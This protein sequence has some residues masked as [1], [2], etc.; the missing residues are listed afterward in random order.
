M[1]RKA[2]QKPRNAA[3]AAAVKKD[4][5]ATA[6]DDARLVVNLPER[7]H[8]AIKLRAVERG[9]SIRDY[10]L[11]LLAADKLPME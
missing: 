9:I 5:K 4:R 7:V 6:A 2:A 8:R 10:I 3:R 1:A 11:G